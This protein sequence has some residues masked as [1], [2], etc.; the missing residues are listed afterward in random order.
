MSEGG[1]PGFL[2][3]KD[4]RLLQKP[5]NK[6]ATCLTVAQKKK[7]ETHQTQELHHQVLMRLINT[8]A[9]PGCNMPVQ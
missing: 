5:E 1:C 2:S 4:E 8:S 7:K 6:A 3:K 9:S